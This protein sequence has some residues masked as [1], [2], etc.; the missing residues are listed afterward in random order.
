M[1][2][3]GWFATGRGEGSRGLLQ[4]V[5][6]RILQGCLDAR[7]EFVFSNRAPGEAEGSD[8]F[9]QMAQQY[10]LPLVTLSSAQFRRDRGGR[11]AALRDEYDAAVMGLLENFAPRICVMAGY[12]LIVGGAMCR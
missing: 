9:F 1:L 5:E 4:F 8:Q 2:N 3:I 11:W 6:E 12:M 7:I 10:G